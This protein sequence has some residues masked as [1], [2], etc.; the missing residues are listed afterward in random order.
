MVRSA[1]PMSGKL[2]RCPV[3]SLMSPAHRRWRVHR[4]H[5]Q[6]DH[7][8]V[9]PLELGL[10]RRDGAQLGGADRREVLGMREQDRPS[11]SPSTRGTQIGPWVVSAV[12]SG[13]SSP[14]RIVIALLPQVK[15]RILK[16]ARPPVAPREA[17]RRSCRAV[18]AACQRAASPKGSEHTAGDRRHRAARVCIHD[19]E[20]FPVPGERQPVT[21][22][23][24]AGGPPAGSASDLGAGHRAG[25]LLRGECHGRWPPRPLAPGG[26]ARSRRRASGRGNH[27]RHAGPASSRSRTPSPSPT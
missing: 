24:A 13:A 11:S 10:E 26:P 15:C 21:W 18:S 1:S 8:H 7:L 12:K 25:L 17:A 20:Y 9:P 19:D 2:S 3:T 14:S 4:V 23:A 22:R 5:A 6:A 16:T 27:G